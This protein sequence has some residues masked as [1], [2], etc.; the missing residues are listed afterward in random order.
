MYLRGGSY[1]I[2]GTRGTMTLGAEGLSMRTILSKEQYSLIPVN[3]RDAVIAG[4]GGGIYVHSNP[5][6]QRLYFFLYLATW[7]KKCSKW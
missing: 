7:C 6:K 1:P 3:Q 5:T 2:S 4:H